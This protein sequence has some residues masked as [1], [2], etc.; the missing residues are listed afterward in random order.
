MKT[1]AEHNQPHAAKRRPLWRGL[2]GLLLLFLF[3]PFSLHSQLLWKVSGKNLPSPSYIFGTHHLIP[4]SFLDSV[5]ELFKTFNECNTVVSEIVLNNID[6]SPQIMQAAL[7]PQGMAMDSLLNKDDYAFVDAELKQILKIG[8]RE[9]GL[10]NP[11]MIKTLYGLELY[12]QTTGFSEN[13]QSDSYLQTLAA[14]VDKKIIGLE[15][16]EK[17]IEVLFGNKDLQ[18]E[19]ELLVE[20]VRAKSQI[21]EEINTLNTIYKAGKIDELVN[22]TKAKDDPLAMTDEEYAEMIDNRNFE[23]LEVLPD[24]MAASSCFIA[25]GALHLGGENG[26]VNQLR[27]KGYK[28]TEVKETKSS[29]RSKK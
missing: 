26:L 25:V 28:V 21:L 19:A 13:V 4:I 22:M 17:Q 23:W 15:S 9:L 29:K 1:A 24:Y 11:S 6:A 12:K 5:P 27:K 7:L 16:V 18:H 3:I 14:R 20:T 2:G 10:M 8:L